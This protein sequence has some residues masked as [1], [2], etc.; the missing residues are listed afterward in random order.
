MTDIQ[1]DTASAEVLPTPTA[2]Q[3]IMVHHEWGRLTEVVVGVPNIRIPT[4]LAEAPKRFLPKASIEFM[5]QNPGKLLSEC[6]PDVNFK[7]IEQVN[8]IIRILRDR[9]IIVHQVEKLEPWEEAFLG[10]MN[11]T[12]MQTF[13]RDTILVIGDKFIETAMFEPNRRK[14]RFAIRRT[15]KARL[16]RNHIP[17][18]TMLEPEP[19]PADENGKYGPGP[20]LESGDVMLVGYDIYVGNTGNASNPAGMRWLQDCL[21][22]KY[23]VHEIMLSSHFLHLDCVLAL[24]RPGLAIICKE[25]FINGVP[26][27]LKGWTLIEVSPEDAEKKLGCNGLVL[28]EKTMIIGSDMPKLAAALRAEGTEVLTTPVDAMTWQGGGFRCWHHPLVRESKL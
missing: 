11:D 9:G 6:A 7:F 2:G 4:K 10:E 24:P 15:L 21:G 19:Y 8:G 28:D 1:I 13:A 3:P 25:G 12:T 17:I 5:E 18:I 22:S 26:E 16:A 23:R 14:E 20:F 27:F